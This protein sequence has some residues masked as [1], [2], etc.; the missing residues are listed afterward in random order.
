M[1]ASKVANKVQVKTF[2]SNGSN[3]WFFVGSGKKVF[4]WC[5]NDLTG[6]NDYLVLH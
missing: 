5:A 2:S 3:S 4:G 6:T 1:S